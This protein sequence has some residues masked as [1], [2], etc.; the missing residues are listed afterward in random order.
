MELDQPM[1]W[2]HWLEDIHAVHLD[3]TFLNHEDAVPF[4]RTA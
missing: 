1:P 2:V 3:A 4:L